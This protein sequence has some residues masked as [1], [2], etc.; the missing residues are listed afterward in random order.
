M[1]EGH[2]A[3]RAYL[4]EFGYWKL[5]IGY[6]IFKSHSPTSPPFSPRI[7]RISTDYPSTSPPL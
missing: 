2:F 4:R 3:G 6:W 1:A 5:D 7:T